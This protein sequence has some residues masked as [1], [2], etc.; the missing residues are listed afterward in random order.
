MTDQKKPSTG[1]GPKQIEWCRTNIPHFKNAQDKAE[2]A[3]EDSDHVRA[4]MEDKCLPQP[5]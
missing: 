5:N 3:R 1:L 4:L 2:A